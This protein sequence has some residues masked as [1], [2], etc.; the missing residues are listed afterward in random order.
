M[1]SDI[2]ELTK[3]VI[4]REYDK[5]LF[6]RCIEYLLYLNQ[7]CLREK[8]YKCQLSPAGIILRPCHRTRLAPSPLLPLCGSVPRYSLLP[9]N[10]VMRF[11]LC[12]DTGVLLWDSCLV[13]DHL[14]QLNQTL[15]ILG[16]ICPCF[17]SYRLKN[18]F[19]LIT[20]SYTSY[21]YRTYNYVTGNVFSVLSWTTRFYYTQSMVQVKPCLRKREIEDYICL[22]FCTK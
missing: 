19:T 16:N 18:V 9:T 7:S 10:T 20:K 2:F 13:L 21:R 22:H 5:L 1:E 14:K 12:A 3:R 15:I 17:Y 8:L 11:I 6:E 4:G